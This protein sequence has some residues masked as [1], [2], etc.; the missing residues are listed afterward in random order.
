M[1]TVEPHQSGLLQLLQIALNGGLA[2]AMFL[3]DFPHG[4][5]TSAAYDAAVI[6]GQHGTR[7]EHATTSRREAMERGLS[8]QI[9]QPGTEG[10]SAHQLSIGPKKYVLQTV[11][12][13]LGTRDTLTGKNLTFWG[14]CTYS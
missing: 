14:M 3:C 1:D 12:Y 10:T 11:Q 6:I 9:V 5:A 8:A 13:P 2:E 4:Q 7:Q